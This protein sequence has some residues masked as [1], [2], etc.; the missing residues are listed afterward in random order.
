MWVGTH[1]GG[2][3]RLDDNYNVTLRLHRTA[4]ISKRLV[5]DLIFQ[6]FIDKLNNLWITHAG[7]LDVYNLDTEEILIHHGMNMST[8]NGDLPKIVQG[9]ANTVI[10]GAGN[11][12][13]FIDS[14]LQNRTEYS[15][16]NEGFKIEGLL[17]KNGE[18]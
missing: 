9:E 6:L 11:T 13:Y 12:L 4:H 16:G 15:L 2:V 17:Y 3:C 7:G 5:S 1:G 18:I 8:L 14:T 10:V